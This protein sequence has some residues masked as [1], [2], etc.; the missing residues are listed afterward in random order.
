MPLLV[1]FDA[2][3]ACDTDG[4]IVT[5]SWD[6]GDGS[7]SIRSASETSPAYASHTYSLEGTYSTALT[8]IDNDGA[9]STVSV[10]IEV[11]ASPVPSYATDESPIAS[12]TMS[13]T[14]GQAPLAVSFD[15]TGSSDADGAITSYVWN[16][17]DGESSTGATAAHTYITEGSYTAQLTVTDDDGNQ[18]T[19]SRTVQALSSS[20]AVINAPTASVTASP[21]S[22]QAPLVVDFDASDSSDSDG[23]IVSYTWEFDDGTTA[24]GV[25]AT[26]TYATPG[27][28]TVQLTVMDSDFATSIEWIDIEVSASPISNDAPSATFTATP[29]SGVAPLTVSFD[30]SDSSDSDG[31]ITSYSW[32]FGDGETAIGVTT[33]HTYTSGGSYTAQLTVM[34]DDGA[35][36]TGALSME[37]LA[38]SNLLPEILSFYVYPGPQD[39]YEAPVDGQIRFSCGDSD[40]VIERWR[41]D[42]GD[43]V[44][45]ED[46]PGTTFVDVNLQAFHTY[47]LPG[48]KRVT[49]TV[50]DNEG[51]SA[52]ESA[53]ICPITRWIEPDPMGAEILGD[54]YGITFVDGAIC[55]C[56]SEGLWFID[57]STSAVLSSM[58]LPGIKGGYL[59]YDGAFL[60]VNSRYSTTAFKMDLN[61]GQVV[62]SCAVPG[63]QGLTSEDDYLWSLLNTS[64]HEKLV[65]KVDPASGETVS[66]FNFNYRQPQGDIAFDG[67][68]LWIAHEPTDQG[69]RRFIKVDPG[70]GS[71]LAFFDMEISPRN[72]FCA[73]DGLLWF[74]DRGSGSAA[75]KILAL[76]PEL[77]IGWEW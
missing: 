26:H 60:W 70:T 7:T 15:A 55:I 38:D 44:V 45:L 24:F 12:F 64:T 31:T 36:D 3:L 65:A 49:L 33:N 73:G 9:S 63:G 2:S 6:F 29:V 59:A 10:Q 69:I 48:P 22:G 25:T 62:D 77:W 5:Y 51:K 4:D 27:S 52:T 53:T 11:T 46:M 47:L 34:D 1:T 42:T 68:S 32:D 67:S 72:G 40:G 56:T 16:F 76:D 18:D 21:V 13:P 41:I 28:Y 74:L 58:P 30:A 17:G 20:S 19:A 57:P 61:T 35:T 50:W 43:G 23:S 14:S 37:V 54:P 71:F 39:H 8:V 75:V 66:W